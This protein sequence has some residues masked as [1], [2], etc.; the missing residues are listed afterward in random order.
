MGKLVFGSKKKQALRETI[1]CSG[2]GDGYEEF[3]TQWGQVG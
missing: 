1:N 2:C 3:I